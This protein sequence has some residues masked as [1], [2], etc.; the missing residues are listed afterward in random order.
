M[1][2]EFSNAFNLSNNKDHSEVVLTFSHVFSEHNFSMKGGA[3]TDVSGQVV[4][5]LAS[6]IMT[7]QGAVALTRMLNKMMEDWDRE[8]NM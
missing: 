5:Q 2:P 6:I 1:K 7:H 3:M 8:T 4:Q